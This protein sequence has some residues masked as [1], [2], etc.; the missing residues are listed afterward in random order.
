MTL[1][2]ML[3][4]AGILWTAA[5]SGPGAD[6]VTVRGRVTDAFTYQPIAYATVV[7]GDADRRALTDRA[8]VF[9]LRGMEPG[10]HLFEVSRLGYEPYDVI[11]TVQPGVP[12]HIELHPEPVALEAIVA[13]V[14][15]LEERTRRIPYN[16]YA[17]GEAELVDYGHPNLAAFLDEKSWLECIGDG[18]NTL[19]GG[20]RRAPMLFIDEIERHWDYLATLRTDQLY[21]VEFVR[22]CPMVRV[23]TRAFMERVARGRAR[24]PDSFVADCMDIRHRMGLR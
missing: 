11:L 14:D 10:V 17:W 13:T 3:L 23:Y 19:V 8:G 2:S 20:R 24:L 7:V 21:R 9:V 1:A 16:V 6:T 22:N 18:C 5:A 12:L 15:R 4:G